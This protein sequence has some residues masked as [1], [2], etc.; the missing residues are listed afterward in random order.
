[1]M[2][3]NRPR[4]DRPTRIRKTNKQASNQQQQHFLIIVLQIHYIITTITTT[5]TSLVYMCKI[6]P[7][8]FLIIK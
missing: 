3:T 2:M 4:T 6:L 1:M 7:I 8:Y 5:T